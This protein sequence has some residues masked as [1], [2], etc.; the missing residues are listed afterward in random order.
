MVSDQDKIFIKLEEKKRLSQQQFPKMRQVLEKLAK[1]WIGKFAVDF[2][3]DTNEQRNRAVWISNP[4]SEGLTLLLWHGTSQ[5]L[6]EIFG[7]DTSLRRL[8]YETDLK[9]N[10][11]YLNL[12]TNYSET[13]KYIISITDDDGIFVDE[14]TYIEFGAVNE[15]EEIIEVLIVRIRE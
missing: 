5:H 10:L 2:N 3:S 15:L 1:I 12:G 9:K 8:F 14:P 7:L 6:Q 4:N 11:V 13:T